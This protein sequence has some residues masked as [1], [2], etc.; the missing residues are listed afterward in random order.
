MQHNLVASQFDDVRGEKEPA[1]V[2]WF[3]GCNFLAISRQSSRSVSDSN[4]KDLPLE[5]EGLWLCYEWI[6]PAVPEP[7][8]CC[9]HSNAGVHINSRH[10]A[11]IR[12]VYDP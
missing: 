9:C 10:L 6:L 11:V 7:S 8:G 2:C 12:E 1:G 4:V 5:E 3:S